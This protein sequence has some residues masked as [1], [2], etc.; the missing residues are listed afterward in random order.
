MNQEMCQESS[1]FAPAQR[2]V[3]N[4]SCLIAN[5]NRSGEKMPARDAGERRRYEPY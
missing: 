4:Q 1:R 2:F 5:F 3:K